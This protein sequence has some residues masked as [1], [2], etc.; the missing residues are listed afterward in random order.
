MNYSI[1]QKNLYKNTFNFN[2]KLLTDEK[3]EFTLNFLLNKIILCSRNFGKVG[4]KR[5]NE[6]I[7]MHL[8]NSG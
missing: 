2:L 5:I 7:K 1:T 8:K 4:S 6:S 3:I